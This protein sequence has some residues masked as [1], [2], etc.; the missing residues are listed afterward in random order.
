[1]AGLVYVNHPWV[2]VNHPWDHFVYGPIWHIQYIFLISVGGDMVLNSRSI[3]YSHAWM[4]CVGNRPV[5]HPSTKVSP[6]THVVVR[7]GL[8]R[9]GLGAFNNQPGMRVGASYV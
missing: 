7:R 8:V 6:G 4:R 2:Y 3:I 9:V 1:M 5:S